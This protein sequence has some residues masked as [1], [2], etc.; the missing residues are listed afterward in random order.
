M[1]K[2]KLLVIIIMILCFSSCFAKTQKEEYK[3]DILYSEE[4]FNYLIECASIEAQE[5]KE[6]AKNEDE[7]VLED[8]IKEGDIIIESMEPFKLSIEENF[9]VRPYSETFKKIDTK[10]II[11]LNR[12]FSFY[13]NMSKTRNKYN[14]N[15]YKV[16][17]GAEAGAGRLF[18]LAG[19]METNYRGFDQNPTSRK[20]YL[21]P[22]LNITDR[23]SLRFH[24][25]VNVQNHV[26]DHDVELKI[27]PFKSRALDFGIYAATSRTPSGNHSESINFSTTFYFF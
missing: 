16:L 8:E 21:T 10:T 20:L 3:N 14:S 7:V 6:T 15:D 17:A 9:T 18:S 1:N 26:A 24:N 13:Q 4:Y 22:A 12:D 25:K 5:Q 19:G 27:T 11:P 2:F 23:I